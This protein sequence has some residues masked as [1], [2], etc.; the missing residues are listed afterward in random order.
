MKVEIFYYVYN[1]KHTYFKEMK[2]DFLL[3]GCI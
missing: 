3:A 1:G 2:G